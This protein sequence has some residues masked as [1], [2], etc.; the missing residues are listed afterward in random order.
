MHFCIKVL[1]VISPFGWLILFCLIAKCCNIRALSVCHGSDDYDGGYASL[2]FSMSSMKSLCEATHAPYF[3]PSLPL[4]TYRVSTW[5]SVILVCCSL[6]GYCGHCGAGCLPGS[7]RMLGI[8]LPHRL[9]VVRPF[10]LSFYFISLTV[11]DCH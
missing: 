5:S 7:A 1:C 2:T 9:R 10:C 8:L 11:A 4:R 6:S 3:F